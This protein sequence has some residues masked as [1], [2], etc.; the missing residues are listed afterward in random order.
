M[1]GSTRNLRVY[2][3][4][5]P[6]DL[7]NGFNGLYGIIQQELG[8]DPLSGDVYLFVNRRRKSAKALLYDGT[9]LCIYSKRLAEGTFAAL[10]RDEGH[11]ALIM[12]MTELA[13]FLEG[14][15]LAEH[16]PLTAKEVFRKGTKDD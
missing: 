14:A 13:L 11:Q 8:H 4:A 2:A 9:G 15:D 5:T 10:W 12:S 3:R 16:L 1:I 6:T 7:R